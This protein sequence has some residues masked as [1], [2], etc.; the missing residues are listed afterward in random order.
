M[1]R[2]LSSAL[3]L[4][5]GL[6]A[7]MVASPASA[8]TAPS[9]PASCSAS[10]LSDGG[11]RVGWTRPTDDGGGVIWRY[12]VKV[13]GQKD[14]V[15]RLDSAAKSTENATRAYN[16]AHATNGTSPLTFQVRAVNSAGYST[17]CEALPGAVTEPAPSPTPDPEP[18][19]APAPST[20]PFLP[21]GEGSF[22]QSE[23]AGAPL[24]SSLTSSFRS[25]MKTHPDQKS[26]PY[27]V[28]RGV[29][30]NLW[31]SVYGEGTSSDPVW[32]IRTHSGYGKSQTSVLMTQ[33]FRA[34]EWLG[35]MITGTSDSPFTIIDRVNG[36][37]VRGDKAAYAGNHQ[38]DIL[39]GGSTAITYHGSNGLD[40]RNP[41]ADDKR[42]FMSRGRISDAMI[43]RDLVDH[44]IA[45]NTD[46]GHVLH[47][48][49]AETLSSAGFVHPMVGTESGKYGWGAEGV[50]IAIDPSVDLTKRGLSPAGLVVART[51]QNYGAYVGDN[52]GNETSI[53]A[54][55]E[56]PG[57]M[58]WN[59]MLT[60]DS[61]KGI[62]W[63]DFVVVK[64]A[65]Q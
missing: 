28:I 13:K 63:D 22:F 12:V 50:R 48:Y 33:G 8:V 46:L 27:P 40:G 32:K 42:N 35:D 29:G 44:G 53:Q 20:A 38:I 54:E 39:T 30:G 61:L 59:G 24:D 34:P 45:K 37:T 15:I 7:V 5:T 14:P 21:Y 26:W 65:W 60:K 10:V 4:S 62:T 49:L 9:A 52:A 17:W 31:G 36:F 41:R 11:F 58:V 16:W 55:V 56:K 6:V 19:P 51:L 2:V 47:L 57:H 23:V 25:F 18:S 3:A 1:K 43:R 64:P